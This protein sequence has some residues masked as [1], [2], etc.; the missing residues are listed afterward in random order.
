MLQGQSQRSTIVL[1][2]VQKGT[3][4]MD[5]YEFQEFA[6]SGEISPAAE[7]TNSTA[8]R[9]FL[10]TARAFE[11]GAR[12][13]VRALAV[14]FA[15]PTVATFAAVLATLAAV[16]VLATSGYLPYWAAVPINAIAI[17]FIFAPLHEATHGNIAGRDRRHVWLES[18]IGHASGFVLLAPYPGFRVLHLHHHANTNDPVEDPDYWVKSPTWFG[19]L[20]RSMVIQPVYILH[21]WKIAR[22]PRTMRA[23]VWEMV[24]MASYVAIIL[25][26]WEFGFGK[27]L[28]LLWI[29]PGYI[30]VVLC[31]VMFD[32][33]VHHPHSTR[34]R[35]KDSAILLFP[36]PFRTFMD[37]VFCGHTYHLMHHL[38]P[39]LPFYRYGKAWNALKHELL[40]LDPLVREF[41]FRRRKSAHLMPGSTSSTRAWHST[42]SY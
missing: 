25:A 15:W 19:Q 4:T 2:P 16:V 31:P 36:Q 9:A 42:H 34:G 10:E 41:Q 13:A 7:S 21:L 23:F 30:G 11:K 35:Y 22:D 33:P 20:V 17:Y 18:L 24:C 12:A 3:R 37:V 27:A 39:R 5:R 26:A 14:G 1:A 6:M 28:M 40:A 32:W 29:L 38:Y 8:D